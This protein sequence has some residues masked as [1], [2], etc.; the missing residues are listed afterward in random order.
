MYIYNTLSSSSTS[1]TALATNRSLTVSLVSSTRCGRAPALSRAR[2]ELAS[3]NGGGGPADEEEEEEEGEEEG[4]GEDDDDDKFPPLLDPPPPEEALVSALQ[5][6]LEI[7]IPCASAYSSISLVRCSH[8]CHRR[9]DSTAAACRRAT[10]SSRYASPAAVSSQ[11]HA[12]RAAARARRCRLRA[13]SSFSLDV[14]DDEAGK[15]R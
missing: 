12:A 5:L 7:V 9:Q 2:S 3:H 14:N 13:A 6:G 11:R 15:L 4:E 10:S 1:A 8:R